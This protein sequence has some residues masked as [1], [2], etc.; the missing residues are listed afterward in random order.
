MGA[1]ERSWEGEVDRRGQEGETESRGRLKRVGSA[2]GKRRWREERRET[3]DPPG[4]EGPVRTHTLLVR[5]HQDDASQRWLRELG[6]PA[7]DTGQ[8]PAPKGSVADVQRPRSPVGVA[9]I[10]EEFEPTPTECIVRMVGIGNWGEVI[11]KALT[12]N[13]VLSDTGANS[14][15]ADSEAHLTGCHDIAPVSVGLALKSGETTVMHV[16][17]RM[18]YMPLA[19]ED[20][21][22]HMQPFLVNGAATDCILSPD[23]IAR[24]SKDCVSWRQVGHVGDRP[25]TLEFFDDM[26]RR[27]MR[28]QLL[29]NNGL[30]YA[31]V[32]DVRAPRV[33]E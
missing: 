2:E 21:T 11:V 28:L 13:G 9:E 17:T 19:W 31:D 3:A 6:M 15:M 24:Q 12:T 30:Y 32:R 4:R 27:V 29:K 1:D 14:C 20:G 33:D 18:G 23:A 16:C 25:G 22:T 26:G 5:G 10:G 8:W 7:P